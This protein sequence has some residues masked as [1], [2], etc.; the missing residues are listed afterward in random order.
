MLMLQQIDSS[1]YPKTLFRV[2]DINI[3][4]QYSHMESWF[5][6][7]SVPLNS[8]P[9]ASIE[10]M[11][12]NPMAGQ[13]LR[14]SMSKS[15]QNMPIVGSEDPDGVA[16]AHILPTWTIDGSISELIAARTKNPTYGSQASFKGKGVITD[17]NP[18][19]S[20]RSSPHSIR[21]VFKPLSGTRAAFLQTKSNHSVSPHGENQDSDPCFGHECNCGDSCDCLG[22]P[23]HPFNERTMGFIRLMKDILNDKDSNI[24]QVDISIIVDNSR[25]PSPS[26]CFHKLFAAPKGSVDA[27][28]GKV[29]GQDIFKVN[30]TSRDVK[31][32]PAAALIHRSNAQTVH[33]T[34][35]TDSIA[36]VNDNVENQS[37]SPSEFFHLD[38]PTSLN[39]NSEV[40]ANSS[41]S[42]ENFGSLTESD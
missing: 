42:L 28:Q 25:Q 6:N 8:S 37:F 29:S 17:T 13:L 31:S 40:F 3:S 5:D 11:P 12:V 1:V 35:S 34:F 15:V 9:G 14:L 7:T 32:F 16:K 36:G 10:Q 19:P 24:S 30:N 41:Y 20:A 4:G 39:E 21:S 33:S 26:C 22:C 2:A 23:F 27:E 18:F 38:Y